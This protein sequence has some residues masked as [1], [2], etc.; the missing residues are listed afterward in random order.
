MR[1]ADHI[2]L[3]VNNNMLTAA[4]FLDIEIA[5]EKTRHNHDPAAPRTYLALFADDACIFARKKHELLVLCKLQR[6]LTAV[7]SWCGDGT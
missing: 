3:N 1:L 4:I 7:N 6:G 2:T 5:F